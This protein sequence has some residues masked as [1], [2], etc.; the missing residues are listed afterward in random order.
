MC[1]NALWMAVLLLTTAPGCYFD[2]IYY[3]DGQ[4]RQGTRIWYLAPN[5]GSCFVESAW[6]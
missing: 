2:A 6:A 1:K 5:G 3:Q 4:V